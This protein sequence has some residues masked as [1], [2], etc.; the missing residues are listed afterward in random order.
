MVAPNAAAAPAPPGDAGGSFDAVV[1]GAGLVGLA[2]A[3]ALAELGLRVALADRAPVALPP[4]PVDERD[5]DA[6]VYAI[7]PGSA[8]FL[9][10]IGAWQEVPS[11][12]IATVE[13][14]AVARLTFSAFDLGE[15]ALAWIVEERALRSALI[16][17]LHHAG[18]TLLAPRTVE[19]IAWGPDQARL[20]LADGA[21]VVTRLI[22]AA[23]GLNSWVR[24]VAGISA[25]FRSYRQLGVVANFA[26]TRAHHGWAR[27]WFL[28]RDGILAWLP[29]PGRRL[30]M[31]W[32]APEALAGQLLQLAP[33][34]L[35]ARVAAIGGHAAGTLECITPAAGYPLQLMRLPTTIGHRLVL[36][37]DAAHGVHPLAGQGVNLGFGDVATLATVLRGRGPVADIGADLLLERCARLRV[38]PV[39]AMQAITDG[40]WHLFDADLPG[41]PALRNLGLSLAD[42]LPLVK[43]LLAQSALR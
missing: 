9:R 11:E 18:V 10:G 13:A 5:W 35:A 30:S 6:R 16:L 12:R 23:D 40:L 17:R 15:R 4:D 24:S 7:S 37:G 43:R 32:S 3:C 25:T 33:D 21:T 14:M 41:L 34:A 19:A 27:Q 1:V 29:L 20:H 39:R 31:V 42:R 8:A 38:E 36:V 22:V 26:C 28:G 2:A